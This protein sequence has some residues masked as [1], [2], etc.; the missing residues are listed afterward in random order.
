LPKRV[1]VMETDV[2]TVKRLI[3]DHCGY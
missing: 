2:A 3:A 1:H